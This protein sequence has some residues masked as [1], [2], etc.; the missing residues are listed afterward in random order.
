MCNGWFAVCKSEEIW[1]C[2]KWFLY[3][4]GVSGLG[5]CMMRQYVALRDCE[6]ISRIDQR[7]IRVFGNIFLA[8]L[9]LFTKK[10]IYQFSF[11]K[12]CTIFFI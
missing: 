1:I 3:F 8:C 12:C 2:G 4:G 7:V 5:W 6:V 9:N 11:Y 10:L